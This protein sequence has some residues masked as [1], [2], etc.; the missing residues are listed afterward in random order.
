MKLLDFSKSIVQDVGDQL[1]SIF[2]NFKLFPRLAVKLTQ[3]II[4]THQ[5]NDIF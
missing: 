1:W 3:A 4:K 2:S 5:L